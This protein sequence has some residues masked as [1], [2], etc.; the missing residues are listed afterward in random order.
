M[1][2]NAHAPATRSVRTARLDRAAREQIAEELE[3]ARRRI[4]AIAEESE[5][6]LAADP[7]DDG[8]DA[9]ILLALIRRV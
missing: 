5:G 1:D 6:R 2:P 7:A 9:T 8:I 4:A 3:R